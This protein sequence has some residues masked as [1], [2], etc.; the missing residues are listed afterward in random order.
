MIHYEPDKITIN[1]LSL[2]EVIIDVVVRYYGISDSIIIDRR[3]L[4]ISKLWSL[5][6]Y[7][8]GI[9]QKLSIAFHPQTDGRTERQ[10]STMKAYFQVSVNFKQID[11]ARLFSM[12]EFAY[13]NAKNA[14]TG[15]T[16]FEL[17][18]KYHPCVSYKEDLDP[19]SKLK[20]MEELFSELRNLIAVY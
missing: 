2:A 8:L 17:N 19:R 20:I 13:N 3:F 15:H 4:F 7:F 1:A 14:S 12:I 18:C 9:K 5:L 6:F 10:N 16:L 11:C